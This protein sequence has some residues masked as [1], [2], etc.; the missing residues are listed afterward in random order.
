MAS[1]KNALIT[2]A[3]T[4]IQRLTRKT[5]TEWMKEANSDLGEC[6]NGR[7][8]NSTQ[9]ILEGVIYL[10]ASCFLRNVTGKKSQ[11]RVPYAR[12]IFTQHSPKTNGENF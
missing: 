8:K 9:S 4:E 5:M 3:I 12:I 10:Y 6:F 2:R 11:K 1:L 7:K